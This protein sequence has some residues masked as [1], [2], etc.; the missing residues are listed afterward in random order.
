MHTL[1]EI[2]AVPT[3]RVSLRVPV[4]LPGGG[5]TWGTYAPL[6]DI[7][8]NEYVFSADEAYAVVHTFGRIVAT[9]LPSKE[10][11]RFSILA[12][13]SVTGRLIGMREWHWADV[14]GV[15]EPVG[16]Y[17]CGFR[18]AARELFRMTGHLIE[19]MRFDPAVVS[20]SALSYAA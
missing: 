3:L 15:F 2:E 13:G 1:N 12:N 18:E 8:G 17:L 14:R 4:A 9:M 5:W 11:Q 19:L 20:R 10:V 6:G 7:L 16:E